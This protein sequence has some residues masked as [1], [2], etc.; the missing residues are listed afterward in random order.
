MMLKNHSKVHYYSKLAVYVLGLCV[1][2][3]GC[4]GSGIGGK[5]TSGTPSGKRVSMKGIEEYFVGN[6][7]M[8]Y[9]LIPVA[10][11]TP[12]GPT[13]VVDLTVRD[14]TTAILW[15]TLRFSVTDASSKFGATD[16]VFVGLAQETAFAGMPKVLYQER[17]KSG[18]AIIS[19]LEVP[20]SP[21]LAKK[22]LED[23]Q[24][25]LVLGTG[26]GRLTFTPTKKAKKRLAS[27]AAISV[28]PL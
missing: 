6:G 20:L 12:K 3:P 4:I 28:P 16:S 17:T 27:F 26:S 18:K 13:A 11:S 25:T 5:R 15:A 14:T 19:R 21:A 24:P 10:F 2:A 1:L 9:Y 23:R 7:V 8:Q 22:M